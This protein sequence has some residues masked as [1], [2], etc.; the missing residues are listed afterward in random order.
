[1]E[2]LSYT[3]AR[4]KFAGLMDKVCESHDPVIITRQQQPSVI[5]MSL[6]DYNALE[7]TAY[8]LRRPA[9]ATQLN[10]AVVDFR[11]NKNFVEV[12]LGKD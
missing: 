5:I 4:N 8:L 9:N 7:E 11:K 1:M 3:K 10:K 2:V 6:E 12:E